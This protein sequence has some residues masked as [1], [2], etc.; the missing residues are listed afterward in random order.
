MVRG[1]RQGMHNMVLFE[2]QQDGENDLI[3]GIKILCSQPKQ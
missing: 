3:P 2:H 1:G